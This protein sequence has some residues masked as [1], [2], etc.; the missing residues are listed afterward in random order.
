MAKIM[1]VEDDYT[2]R[3]LLQSLLEIEGHAVVL[4]SLQADQLLSDL[5]EQQPDLL[6][7][8]VRLAGGVNGLDLLDAIRDDPHLKHTRIIMTSGMD[9]YHAS[10]EAGADD[11]LQK[12]YMPNELLK[13]M[14][15]LLQRDA[16][17]S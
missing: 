7:M 13:A 5:R 3:S 8:D 4:G 11:F 16:P 17:A 1:L 12:P 6:V 10:I 15:K 2:L 14:H 9:Y